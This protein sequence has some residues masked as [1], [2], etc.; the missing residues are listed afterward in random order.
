MPKRILNVDQ[1]KDKEKI[2]KA[3]I[4]GRPFSEITG[5]WGI[6]K[7][8]LSDYLN[9]KLIPAAAKYTAQ[10]DLKDGKFILEEIESIMS[11]MRKLYDACDEYLTDPNNKDKYSLLPRAWEQEIRYLDYSQVTAENQKPQQ[12]TMELQTLLDMMN[13]HKQELVYIKYKFHDPRKIITETATVLTKQLE[14]LARIQGTIKDVTINIINNPMW[15]ELQAIL[16]EVTDQ[17]PEIRESLATRLSKL[18]GGKD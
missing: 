3:L 18:S 16:L 5:K 7:S 17:F 15:I 4:K 12:K 9:D 10:Q 14:L 8:T 1:H 6:A 2:I 13:D 11:K